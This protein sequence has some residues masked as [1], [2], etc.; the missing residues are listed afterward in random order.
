MKKIKEIPDLIMLLGVSLKENGDEPTEEMRERVK[1]AVK[2]YN[3]FKAQGKTCPIIASGG[4][5]GGHKLSEAEV[6]EELL[7]LQGI[8]KNDI[9]REENSCNTAENMR[10]AA[11]LIDKDRPCVLV[12]TSDYHA[13]R[14]ALT[15][16]KE[17]LIADSFG[18]R[19]KH[20]AHWYKVRV[21]EY[22]FTFDLFMGWTKENVIR[23]KW[24]QKILNA[25]I[26]W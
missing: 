9:I 20:D 11:R 2:I 3:D 4:I 25:V 16:R 15:A 12:V 5:T 13:R 23:P 18:A 21:K 8:P 14:A 7:L 1:T 24:F 6:M 19:L 10:F 22:F 26:R 17:G